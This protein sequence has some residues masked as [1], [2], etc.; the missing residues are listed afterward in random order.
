MSLLARFG[1]AINVQHISSTS[2]SYRP[3]SWPPPRDWVCVE[4]KFG[5][6]ISYYG[7]PIWHL[8]P[9]AGKPMTLNFGDGPQLAQ[10]SS[11]DR[12]NADLLRMLVTW[13]GWG[14]RG[15]RTA[16]TLKNT[17]FTPIRQ[18]VAL[19]SREGI[20]A[21]DLMRFPAVMAKVPQVLTASKFGTVVSELQRILDARNELGFILLDQNGI[22]QLVAAKPVHTTEQTEYIP[23]R[24]WAYQV[25]RLRECLDDYIAHRQKV[26]DCFRFCVD[27]YAKNF[28]TLTAALAGGTNTSRTPFQNASNRGD[29]SRSGS[30]YEFHDHFAHTASRFGI[31][32]LLGRWVEAPE[33]GNSKKGITL[34]S[35]YLSLITQVGL[36]YLLNFS[37]MRH[38]EGKS[39]R[40]DCLYIEADE[41]LGKIPILCGETT[42]T[43]P[44]SDAR[45]PTSPS[46]H[47][48]IEAMTSVANLRMTCARE[49]PV[50][51]PLATDI[52]NPYLVDRAFEPWVGHVSKHYSERPGSQGYS[53]VIRKYPK[54]FD[55]KTMEITEQDLKIACS[56]TPT[57]NREMF[58]VG[59]PWSLAHHQLR[60]TGAVN[61]F[62]SGLV[63]DST[64]QFLMKHLTRAMP[65]YYGRGSSSLRL[66]EEARYQLVNAQ[67]EVMGYEIA[68]VISDRFVSPYGDDHKKKSIADSIGIQ[69]EV[70]MLSEVNA[71][72]FEA[73]ARRGAIS[74]R[75]TVLGAC[76]SKGPCDGDCIESIAGCAGGDGG[77]LCK[78]ALFDRQRAAQ[79]KVRLDGTMLILNSTTPDTPKYCALEKEKR[80]LENYFDII[81]R[82]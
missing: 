9:W 59:R 42:K 60:R 69:G 80:G 37:L 75:T 56:V 24:I 67:Y 55:V 20:L 28:G 51:A 4:D 61:M 8:D 39:L 10:T 44:D 71:R 73:A 70:N 23:P 47:V 1:L 29:G 27:A 48:A 76:M 50:V 26:E 2:R 6:A 33:V 82:T 54:L 81:N 36:A 12:D 78:D 35:S 31:L 17:F 14:P 13:R 66:N 5:K 62:G 3:P 79:N 49:N 74:Y 18:I 46:V 34:L 58:Q 68:A 65:L 53:E 25:N 19:C 52:G 72:R 63:S 40:A 77:A 22:R 16:S 21:S 7:Q 15:A 11:I 57:L 32:E 41:K 45:W 30:G 38:D 64:M 43:D